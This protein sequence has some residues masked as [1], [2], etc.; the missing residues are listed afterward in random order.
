MGIHDGHRQRMKQRFLD[1]GLDNFD[2]INTLELLLF[3]VLTWL[4]PQILPLLPG[5]F[6]LLM[7]LTIEPV[8]RAYTTEQDSGGGDA[9]YN[10]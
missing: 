2:D 4:L 7:S 3:L 6:A 10:E 8:F 9:W 1:H 5:V